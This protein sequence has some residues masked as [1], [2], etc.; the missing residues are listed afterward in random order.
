MA[1]DLVVHALRYPESLSGFSATQWDLLVRQ[2]R[3]AGLLA[4]VAH[5]LGQLGLAD[6]VPR[7][8][9]AHLASAATVAAA[10]HTEVRREIAHVQHALR[11]EAGPLVLLKGAAYLAAGLPAAAG[12]VFSDTDILVPKPRL[13]AVETAL[14]MHGWAT[15]HHTPY[16]QR[17]YREWMHELPPL[18]HLRRQTALDVH[19]GISPLTARIRADSERLLQAALPIPGRP[20]L[21][22]LAPADMVLHSMLHLLVND[23]LSHALRD[24]S[25]LDL[26]LRHFGADP[27]FWPG[28]V[29]RA[30]EQ[31]LGRVLHYGLRFVARV[32]GTPV[33]ADV[34]EA[35]AAFA[36]SAPAAALMDTL[37]RRALLPP[38]HSVA[39]GAAHH[40][41]LFMLYVRAHWLR[42]P[43]GLLL[44]HLT[45]KALRRGRE[46]QGKQG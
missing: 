35:C 21:A 34:A 26:L 4:R 12:R 11:D 40:A 6:A 16:D 36:P 18:V 14:V 32:F 29:Q 13:P 3:G 19:H 31:G 1:A 45:V 17:Y 43:T 2:A 15:T 46:P 5:R 37:W 8:P 42:M 22:T 38:H 27:A 25:D 10:Q 33:P 44:R 28:I 30:R 7:A 24:L 41:A 9:A 20:G 23:E 39:G